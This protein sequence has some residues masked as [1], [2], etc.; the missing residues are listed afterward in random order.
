M[1]AKKSANW[2]VLEKGP[3][4]AILDQIRPTDSKAMFSSQLSEVNRKVLDFYTDFQI[5]RVTDYSTLPSFRLEYLGDGEDYYLLDGTVDPIYT[6]ND[7][8][9]LELRQ[10]WV[11]PYLHFFFG[12]A[13][14]ALGQIQLIEGPQNLPLAETLS[15]TQKS[16]FLRLHQPLDAAPNTDDDGFM[17]VCTMLREGALVVAE[18]EVTK[19]GRVSIKN[20]QL[21]LKDQ[22]ITITPEDIR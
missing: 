1:Q 4:R 6:V 10:D 22:T 2:E 5:Y 19:T 20:H 18:L 7:K 11:A 17:V 21:L 8:E 9:E 14:N 15:E 3:G 13:E 16:E 12:H